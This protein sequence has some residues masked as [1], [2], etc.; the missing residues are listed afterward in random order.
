MS[1]QINHQKG[2]FTYAD[3]PNDHVGKGVLHLLQQA[4]QIGTRFFRRCSSLLT[5]L[6]EPEIQFA[7]DFRTPQ[8]PK[9]ATQCNLEQ[10]ITGTARNQTRVSRNA[11]NAMSQRLIRLAFAALRAARRASGSVL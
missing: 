6:S 11:L 2:P 9:H 1:L 4:S 8:G 5:Q 3:P 7:K 10:H